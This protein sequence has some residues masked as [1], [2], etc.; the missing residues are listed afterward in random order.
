[1]KHRAAALDEIRTDL[2]AWGR[3]LDELVDGPAQM[4]TQDGLQVLSD[5]VCRIAVIGQVK[6]GKSSFVNALVGRPGLLPADVNPWT[7]AIT[8]LHFNCANAPEGVAG[9]FAFFDRD[10]WKSIAEGGGRIRELTERLVPGFTPAALS[11]HLETM[12]QR[13]E[14]RLGTEFAK[15]L[16]T[17]HT[18]PELAPGTLE[19][20]VCAGS[21]RDVAGP[22]QYSD[23]TKTADLYFNSNEFGFPAV[24]ID[25]PGTNDPFLVR[26]EIT[27]RCLDGADFH[28]VVLTARQPLSTADVALFRILRGLNKERIVVFVN[29]IDQ[30]ATL[31]Q[32]AQTVA[33]LVH[34]GLRAEFPDIDIPIVVG[35]AMWANA[36]LSVDTADLSSILDPAFSAYAR[37]VTGKDIAGRDVTA[38]PSR[39]L[40]DVL[41]TCSGLPQL[42]DRLTQAIL[43]SHASRTIAHISTGFYELARVGEMT[44]EGDIFRLDHLIQ[45]AANSSETKAH[46]ARKLEENAGRARQLSADLEQTIAGLDRRL[47]ALVQTEC[48]AL[49][50]TLHQSID[51]F[52]RQECLRLG[53]VIAEDKSIRSWRCDTAV[54]RRLI[55]TEY[56][57]R[58]QQ[59]AN[60]IVDPE[61]NIFQ[62]LQQSVADVLPDALLGLELILQPPPITSLSLSVLGKAVVFDLD[63]PWW[64]AW[65]KGRL[66]REDRV[67]E[68]DKL[69]RQ[70][71][72]SVVDDLV[73]AARTRLM[74]QVS[75]TLQNARAVCSSVVE[76]L[77]TQ[78]EWH[79]AKVQELLLTKPDE[80]DDL[81]GE[82]RRNL[83]ELRASHQTWEGIV[84][85]LGEIRDRCQ[86]LL[87]GDPPL[88]SAGLHD[89][90]LE[91]Q[92]GFKP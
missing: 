57:K 87:S 78:S 9:A 54:L 39:E 4:L 48:D 43:N 67:K 45:M 86:R 1:M 44:V 75:A 2:M 28:I 73:D 85:S 13:A 88:P 14:Q 26:D 19:G 46:E 6:A 82:H 21:S 34:D 50:T 58:F 27:R 11:K 17:T 37:Q 10:E 59:T 12:R 32:D 61:F 62:H 23:I 55:E 51:Q 60:R 40:A 49:S 91:T 72:T 89:R 25:T 7:T 79:S 31:P 5:L 74:Q 76:A 90:A 29:R 77:R 84:N 53:E 18:F 24:L 64:T 16:G 66:S 69:I 38:A 47:N 52:S 30:L 56:L 20:Y 41:M 83:A 3:Q 92:G 22:G 8:R 80:S 70:E 36:G 68:L 71:F 42:R 35:S 15:L 63:H 65:W 81:M 33:E